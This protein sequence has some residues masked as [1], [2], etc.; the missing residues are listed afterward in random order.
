MSH[1]TR[2][3]S[4]G[5]G[6]SALAVDFDTRRIDA[7]LADL[8]Q[9]HLP[10]AAVG[11]AIGGK[12]VYRKAFGLASME[13]PTVLAPSTRMRIGSVTKHFTCLA[14]MLLCE[15]GRAGVDDPV[16]KHL[17]E[18][19][20]TTHAVTMRQL[21]GNVGGLRDVY[22]IFTQFNDSYVT[23]AGAAQSVTSADLLSCY[24]HIDDVN[25]EPGTTWSYNN[26]GWLILSTVIERITGWPLEEVL[27]KRIFEPIGM[28]DTLLRRRDDDFVPN[29]CAQHAIR[30]AGG[31]RHLYWG[32]DNLIGAGAMVST[33]DDMLRWL[34]H[35]NAPKVGSAATWA[36]MMA[37]QRLANGTL[38][39]Y[40]LGLKIDRYRG[41]ETLH[42]GGNALGGNARMLKVPAANLNV[43]VLVNRQDISGT[44]L[45]YRILDACLPGLDPISTPPSRRA[46][47]GV[48]RSPATGRIVQLFAKDGRQ[49]ASFGGVDIPLTS[50][51]DG[52][53]WDMEIWRHAKQ[54][55]TLIGD[56]AQP[57][58]IRFHDFGN[59]DELLRQPPA[60]PDRG[61]M[62]GR[63]RSEATDTSASIAESATG[64]ILTTTGRWGSARHELECIARD[65]WRTKPGP[66][67]FVGGIVAL[68]SDAAAFG[69]SSYQTRSLPF[70]R[71]L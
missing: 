43:V 59:C 38:T 62:M 56:P 44:A 24:R 46:A 10:G 18:L 39:G 23:H 3:A 35:M 27:W 21:M 9:C 40:G 15:E 36:T 34:A 26:G 55:V 33:L 14:Y 66:L 41:V 20:P 31:F 11:I 69:F 63:Y 25:A 12:P 67:G 1:N 22:D 16:G 30:P 47:T 52:V 50:D 58:A 42:H 65:I 19:H 6:R 17:P 54:G 53:L 68:T 61:R 64:L 51:E 2:G 48:F 5:A 37:S 70:R 8:D 45:T 4:L 49:M 32:V 57:D 29:S 60:A 71:V 7:I 28:Y 13:L